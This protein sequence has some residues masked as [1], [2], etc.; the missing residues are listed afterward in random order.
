MSLRSLFRLDP[1]LQR[2]H[3][4]LPIALPA[5]L[6]LTLVVALAVQSARAVQVHRRAVAVTLRD[7]AAFAAWQ[8]TRRASDYLRLSIITTLSDSGREQWQIQ[9]HAEGF[10]SGV[11]RGKHIELDRNE[12]Q[13]TAS[14]I[15]AAFGRALEQADRSRLRFGLAPLGDPRAHQFLGYTFRGDS[16]GHP[17]VARGIVLGQQGLR[18]IFDHVAL[19]APL[20]PPSFVGNLP[21]DSLV[22]LEILGGDN[23]PM[24]T[25][26][27]DVAGIT[28]NDVL[29]PDLGG[30]RVV[31]TLHPIATTRLVAGGMPSSNTPA[32]IAMLAVTAVLCAVAVLQMRRTAELI[33]LRDD[34][35]ASV[36]HELK[37]PL[38]QI[39]LFADTLA[40]PR[41]RPAEERKQ[42]L[43]IISREATRLGNLVDGIL[44]FAGMMRPASAPDLREPSLLGEEIRAAISAFEP[45]AD[46]RSVSIHTL[47][48]GEIE[49]PLD[50]DAFRQ[51]M[52]NVLDNA[53]KFGPDGQR[54]IVTAIAGEG[55]ATVRIDDEGPGVPPS[56]R[57]S[58]FEA[59]ARS[60][61]T[62]N[63]LGSGIGLAV[64][65]DVV[66]RHGG[67]VRVLESPAHGAR[68][69][70]ELPALRSVRPDLASTSA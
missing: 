32:L 15:S 20:L 54:I 70:I 29:G 12:T 36:S 24:A 18:P 69:E 45:L 51:V 5:L 8:Y 66:R 9:L 1:S 56:E 33:R 37:T 53:L 26:G 28:A 14:E 58:I 50:R 68:I 40:S 7:Y 65:R 21:N 11:V 38:T 48:D 41:D 30:V 22:S 61:T 60:K 55:R 2:R 23:V 43:T 49:L 16:A 52:L 57:E 6:A 63:K 31:A 4:Q 42:Y 17:V 47:I 35:V 27:R 10:A 64:V 59:F 25:I 67:V 34:F 19:F 3:W 46:A 44:H 39:S 13:L 62:A